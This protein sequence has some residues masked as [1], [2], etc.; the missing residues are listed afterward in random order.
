MLGL[1]KVTLRNGSAALFYQQEDSL[2]R[3]AVEAFRRA[4]DRPMEFSVLGIPRV[5]IDL[6]GIT[7]SERLAYLKNV[8]AKTV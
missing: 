3:E 6:G 2:T 7:E 4:T 5:S 8:L 1:A